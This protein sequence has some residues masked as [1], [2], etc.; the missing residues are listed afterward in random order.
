MKKIFLTFCNTL[1]IDVRATY[2][3]MKISRVLNYIHSLK[4]RGAEKTNP[5]ETK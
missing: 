1:S 2:S 5:L 4:A 3:R